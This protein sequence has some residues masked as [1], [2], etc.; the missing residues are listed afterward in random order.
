MRR[1]RYEVTDTWMPETID[2]S[3][4]KGKK[5]LE[6]GH[7]QGSDLLTFAE[8]GAEV[9]GVDL[10]EEH[11]RLA[12]RNFALHGRPV[13]LKLCDAADLHSTRISSTSCIP[14]A[15]CTTR[16]IPSGASRRFSASSSRA[17]R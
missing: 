17:A 3:I 1:S 13:T 10:T 4:A 11:H 12:T 5:L 2:F 7:G 14:T 6:V 15:S 8:H 9:Y 16:P